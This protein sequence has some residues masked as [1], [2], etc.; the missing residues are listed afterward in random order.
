MVVRKACLKPGGNKTVDL[1]LHGLSLLGAV[2]ALEKILAVLVHVNL[3][4]NNLGG[5]DADGNGGTVG[6]LAVDTLNVDDPLAAV[7]LDNLAL[8]TLEGATDDHDL[9]VLA[10]GDGAGLEVT[11]KEKGQKTIGLATVIHRVLSS[12]KSRWG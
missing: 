12:E 6:L 9:V 8:A 5:V 1:L 3:G 10:D 4:D 2:L 11:N 7:D